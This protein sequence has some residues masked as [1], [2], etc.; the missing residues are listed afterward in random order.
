MNTT[1]PHWDLSNV[2][3]SLESKEFESAVI[4]FKDQLDAFEK[5][6][7]ERINKANISTPAVELG[8]LIGDA[9]DR[10]NKIYDLMWTI[11]PYIQSFVSINSHNTVAVKKMSEHQIV[12]VRAQTVG[13]QFQAWV[14]K[15]ASVLDVT[16]ETNQTCRD[17]AFFLKKTAEQ[18]RYLMSDH[19]ESLAAELSL[20]GSIAWAKLQGTITSQITVDF[21]QSG[22]V[23][24]LPMPALINIQRSHPDEAVRRRAYE[25][26]LKTWESV[27]EPLAA[28]MNGVK[29]SSNVLNKHR[30]RE[31]ALHSAIDEACIDRLTLEAMLDA[32]ESSLSAFRKY[33]KA[34]ARHFGKE[35]LAWWDLFAPLG[36]SEKQYSWEQAG[37][38]ILENFNKFSPELQACAKRA[39]DNNWID[40]HV[41]EG[42]EGGAFCMGIMR[43]KESRVLCNFDGSLEDVLTVAHELG[44][45]FHNECAFNAGKTALQQETPMTL[46]E[47]ASILCETIIL[48]AMLAQSSNPLEELAILEGHLSG[49]AQVIVDIYSR[50]LFEKEIFTRR[51]SSELS[52]DDLCEAMERAQKAAYGDG[53]DE[54]YRHKYMWTWKPHYYQYTFYNFPYAF[55]LLFGIGL[56]AIYQ[57]RGPAFLEEY[58]NL[59][60]STGEASAA[61]LAAHFGIDINSRKFWEDS[62]AVIK[63]RIDRYCEL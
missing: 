52:A 62:L 46:A 17:H 7:T 36:S 18:A 51:E 58:K 60:A 2:Y 4:D 8:A 44:H 53:L 15:L 16:I 56:F 40:A 9:V 48:E 1:P 26:E 5:F 3:P 19:E 23:K 20:S 21:E 43:V 27:R 33:F 11:G 6:L 61:D 49:D 30:G 38:F 41:R 57:Q 37:D 63:K 39:F 28:C 25:T 55:G 34:K 10:L 22:E 54:N 42:K 24:K 32:M 31:D 35:K 47:T 45:A 29:G 59:L 50:F 13:K 12:M 14:G